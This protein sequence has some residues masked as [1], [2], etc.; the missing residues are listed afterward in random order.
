MALHLDR[1]D[2]KLL[3][4]AGYSGLMRGLDTDLTPIFEALD[5]WMPQY[6]A[7]PIGLAMHAMIAGRF[8]DA[9]DA[10]K[11]ILQSD[12][13]GRDEAR[14]IL[15]MCLVLKDEHLEAEKLADDLEG[16]GGH[17]EAFTHVLVHGVD[18]DSQ[19]AQE[20]EMEAVGLR[21]PQ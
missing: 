19:T 14:A 2:M 6:A 13:E 21:E 18:E 4:E 17:A 8:D 1:A 7:G 3:T 9:E 16:T 12:R 5:T 15:A 20:S 11:A 10:L